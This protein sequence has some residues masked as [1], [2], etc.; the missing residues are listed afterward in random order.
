MNPKISLFHDFKDSE[1]L[2]C[3]ILELLEKYPGYGD[4]E[5][6]FIFI[7]TDKVI[8]QIS[9]YKTPWKIGGKYGRKMVRIWKCI[10]K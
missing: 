9:I 6:E 7:N 5:T 8:V 3:V 4:V 10:E 1:T 2:N